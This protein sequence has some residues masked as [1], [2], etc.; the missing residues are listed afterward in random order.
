MSLIR[1]NAFL[2]I[3]EGK[4]RRGIPH[5]EGTRDYLVIAEQMHSV[6]E[7]RNKAFLIS[8]EQSISH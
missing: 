4:Q 1:N 6:R 7:E 5:S 8:K 2:T 3:E